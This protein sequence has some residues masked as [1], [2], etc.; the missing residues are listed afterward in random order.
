MFEDVSEATL[1]NGLRVLFREV[2]T[3]PAV[4]VQIWYG[5]GSRNEVPGITGISH[6]L[7]HM[8]FK[9]TRRFGKGEIAKHLIGRGALFNAATYNDWTRYHETLAPEHVQL[10]LEIEAD[11]MVNTAVAPD[12]LAREIGVVRSEMQGAEND[13]EYQLWVATNA[14]VFAAHPYRWPVIGYQSDLLAMTRD[15]LVRYYGTYYPPNNAVLVLVGNIRRDEALRLTE[16][17]FGSISGGGEIPPVRTQE[18][19]QRGERRVLVRGHGEAARVLMVHHTVSVDHSDYVPLVALQQL[20]DGGRSSRLYRALMDTRLAASASAYQGRRRD[21]Y[22][23]ALDAMAQPHVTV[24]AVERAMTE[25]LDRLAKE[26]PSDQEM[27]RVRNQLEADFEFSTESVTGQAFSLGELATI[28]RWDFLRSYVGA[29][30]ALIPEDLQRV[31]QTY[32]H[33]DNRTVGTFVPIEN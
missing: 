13:P 11:R 25:E 14:A 33:G 20:L 19:P 28:F 16:E 23:F 5:V 1:D 29:V 26:P 7:E 15:D 6:L 2:P 24:E 3:S 9:G 22:L 21:P 32:L 27:E 31:A 8:M 18:P 30:R 4:A 12:E 17:A 10:A